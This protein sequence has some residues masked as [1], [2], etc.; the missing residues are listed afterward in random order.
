MVP[1]GELRDRS[2]VHDAEAAVRVIGAIAKAVDAERA[3]VL[4]CTHAHPGRDGDRRNHALE[5][6]PHALVHQAAEIFQPGIVEND[7]GCSAVQSQDADFHVWPQ[8][9]RPAISGREISNPFRLAAKC[10]FLSKIASPDEP[11]GSGEFVPTAVSP[12]SVQLKFHWKPCTGIARA[13]IG[14]GAW[15]I[16][17]L[18]ISEC[19]G[20]RKALHGLA[21]TESNG[22]LCFQWLTGGSIV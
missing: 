10:L 19:W 11:A 3:G 8:G 13:R 16:P 17:A 15:Q 18:T 14:S 20:C 6:A 22:G 2:G 9:E 1:D 5:A 12:L 7:T 21:R 4:A